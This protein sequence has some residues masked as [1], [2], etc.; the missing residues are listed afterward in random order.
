MWVLVNCSFEPV[1]DTILRKVY[2]SIQTIHRRAV[3]GLR[4][5]HDTILRVVGH[6]G[7]SGLEDP[8]HSSISNLS[9]SS[10]GD[11][12]A[13]S[14]NSLS[15]SVARTDMPSAVDRTRLILAPRTSGV[16]SVP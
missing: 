14:R 7:A 13:S 3:R 10:S 5:L 8:V 9:S 11:R 2:Y 1:H 15:S 12:G 4:G 16:P 6:R